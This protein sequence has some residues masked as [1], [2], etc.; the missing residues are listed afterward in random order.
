MPTV[1]ME[2][3]DWYDNGGIFYDSLYNTITETKR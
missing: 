1:L 3:M 2:L